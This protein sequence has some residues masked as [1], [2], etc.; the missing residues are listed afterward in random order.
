M[1]KFDSNDKDIP[2]YFLPEDS[3]FRLKKLR[4]YTEFLSRLTQPRTSD[5]AGKGTPEVRMG[6]LSVCLAL[7][8][9]QVDLVLEEL[10]RPVQRKAKMKA[11]EAVAEEEDEDEEDED[12]DED[13]ASEKMQQIS[14]AVAERYSFGVTLGQIDSLD[15]LIQTISAHGDVVAGSHEAEFADHTLPRIGQAIYDGVEAVRAILDEVEDQPLGPS[16]RPLNRVGETRATYDAGFVGAAARS[17]SQTG[18]G[19][20]LNRTLQ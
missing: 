11:E 12:E 7:L 19:D 13:N 14:V 18:F 8:S 17:R 15:L 20:G 6:E 10:S 1:S 5:E 16:R 2:G 4:D 3:Q 9:E